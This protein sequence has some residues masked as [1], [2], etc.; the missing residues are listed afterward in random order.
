MDLIRPSVLEDMSRSKILERGVQIYFPHHPGRCEKRRPVS[1]LKNQ[2][3]EF[4][5]YPGRAQ[6]DG[7]Y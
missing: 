1:E 7:H 6:I 3:R 4:K 5:G 2:N